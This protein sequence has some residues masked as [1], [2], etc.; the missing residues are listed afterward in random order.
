MSAAAASVKPIQPINLFGLDR[1][2]R[3]HVQN[4]RTLAEILADALFLG[5]GITHGEYHL[6][7]CVA[8]VERQPGRMN[9][10]GSAVRSNP[11]R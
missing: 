2:Q 9:R 10:E 3:R 1:E 4:L 6:G 11:Y 8:G 7:L 5:E